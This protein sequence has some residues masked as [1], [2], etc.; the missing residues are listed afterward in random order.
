MENDAS[1]NNLYANNY[2]LL[3]HFCDMVLKHPKFVS[4]I[5][6]LSFKYYRCY[7]PSNLKSVRILLTLPSLS[8]TIKHITFSS[9]TGLKNLFAN[10]IKSQSQLSSVNLIF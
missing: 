4:E 7:N 3:D 6:I 8:T 9:I 1:L 5:K 10:I 2:Y